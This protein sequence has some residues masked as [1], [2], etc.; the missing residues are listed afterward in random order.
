MAAHRAGADL[1][2]SL[3]TEGLNLAAAASK[4]NNAE[5]AKSAS[6]L[7]SSVKNA[8]SVLHLKMEVDRIAFDLGQR[9]LVARCSSESEFGG[10]AQA[11]LADA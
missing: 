8:S 7:I 10:P 4:Q 1:I 6:I 5:M 2:G 11:E 3:L 9:T